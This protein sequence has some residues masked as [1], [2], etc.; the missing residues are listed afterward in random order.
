MPGF[1]ELIRTDSRKETMSTENRVIE[2]VQKYAPMAIEVMPHHNLVDD[3]NLDSM[4]LVNL[5]VELEETFQVFFA[6]GLGKEGEISQTT[7]NE[8]IAYLD[9]E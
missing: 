5:F 6:E 2:I 9:G 3:L 4:S 8:I 7:V 1:I